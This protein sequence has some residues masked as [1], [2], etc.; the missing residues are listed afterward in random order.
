MT[1]KSLNKAISQTAGYLE[2][3]TKGCTGAF[4]EQSHGHN[5]IWAW[6]ERQ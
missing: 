5:G 1:S 6:N 3:G 2:A 4:W